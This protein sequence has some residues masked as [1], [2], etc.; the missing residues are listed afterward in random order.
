M[1]FNLKLLF[2]R[3]FHNIVTLI[4]VGTV[5]GS[6]IVLSIWIWIDYGSRYALLFIAIVLLAFILILILLFFWWNFQEYRE[7]HWEKQVKKHSQEKDQRNHIKK[8]KEGHRKKLLDAIKEIKN[9][10]IKSIYK[11]PWFLLIGEPGSGKTRT[12][13]ESRLKF[14]VGRQKIKGTKGTLN[15]DWWFTNEAI[16]IDTAGRF[17]MP[18]VSDTSQ[19]EWVAFLKLL[20]K[21]RPKCPI[22]GVIVTIPANSLLG[23][24][25]DDQGKIDTEI[26]WEKK[27]IKIRD[28]LV[29]LTEILRVEYP[30]YIMV[31][32]LDKVYGFAEFFA[33]FSPEECKQ[34][35]G[36]DMPED[37]KE[38]DELQYSNLFETQVD[39]LHNIALKIVKKIPAGNTTNQIL[40]F[41]NEFNQL[42]SPLSIYLKTIF[43]K[44]IFQLSLLWR[45]CYFTSSIQ[46]GDTK[47]KAIAAGIGENLNKGI[48]DKIKKSYTSESRA[49][50]VHYF[51]K[52]AFREPTLVKP[53]KR[54]TKK[55]KNRRFYTFIFACFLFV[56]SGLLLISGYFSLNK[57]VKPINKNLQSTVNIFKQSEYIYPTTYASTVKDL[58]QSF[59]NGR[60]ELND[61]IT[62]HL[63]LKG[64]Q[65]SIVKNLSHI[66][67]A[68][69]FKGIY[70]PMLLAVRD[71]INSSDIKDTEDKKNIINLLKVYFP[72]LDLSSKISLENI[73]HILKNSQYEWFDITKTELESFW[74]TYSIKFLPPAKDKLPDEELDKIL[75][76]ITLLNYYWQYSPTKK[77]QK[78][79]KIVDQISDS[80]LRILEM[81]I[82]SSNVIINDFPIRIKEFQ[83]IAKKALKESKNINLI[84]PYKIT[85]ICDREYEELINSLPDVSNSN[86]ETIRSN[87]NN[88]RK[89]CND[90]KQY[91]H[92]DW[93]KFLEKNNHLIS[94]EGNLSKSLLTVLETLQLILNVDP[95][96]SNDQLKQLEN[97]DIDYEQ[98][99]IKWCK[100]W[101][102]ELEKINK[103]LAKSLESIK[104]KGW[105]KKTLI[106]KIN[107]YF[108][109]MLWA[110][111]RDAVLHAK[112]KIFEPIT[113]ETSYSNNVPLLAQGNILINKYQILLKLKKWLQNE[114]QGHIEIELKNIFDQIDEIINES[115]YNY[116]RYWNNI[117]SSYNPVEH[118]LKTD[119]WND[120]YNICINKNG[121]IID[122]TAR[123]LNIF[124]ENVSLS[125]LNKF[126]V[127]LKGIYN[128]ENQYEK[129]LMRTAYTYENENLMSSLQS[130]QSD[131]LTNLKFLSNDP[132]VAWKKLN[133]VNFQSLSL[134]TLKI[135]YDSQAN[136]ELY[137]S[138]LKEVEDY[139]VKLLD[140][141]INSLIKN[142]WDTFYSIWKLNLPQRYP[143]LYSP[144]YITADNNKNS[145]NITIN[146]LSQIELD[147]LFYGKNGISTLTFQKQS[148]SNNKQLLIDNILKWRSFLYD[149]NAS[150]RNHKITIEVDKTLA[151]YFS[152][153]YLTGF[154]NDIFL[155]LGGRVSHKVGETYWN[156]DLKQDFKIILKNDVTDLTREVRIDG[157]SLCFFAFVDQN[158]KHSRNKKEFLID[159]DFPP[160]LSNKLKMEINVRF[161]DNIPEI[162]RWQ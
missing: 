121:L 47:A 15:C 84:P 74:E 145:K 103:N 129:K 139:G 43:D 60:N 7:K 96:L 34:I 138:K 124:L 49:Y 141:N 40:A 130:A 12:L 42:Q 113:I 45:G 154:K 144:N 65:N 18:P 16:I 93:N 86:I 81:S 131:F 156:I 89:I 157:G 117:L 11:L 62:V 112:D 114:N 51:Y 128:K 92:K 56:I 106:L 54:A 153:F 78:Q 70:K 24:A 21:Y 20:R 140:K 44:N 19:Q 69:F 48:I 28:K 104:N 94:D 13:M 52:K 75:K 83:E 97:F 98:E 146:T 80:Y 66:E 25:D 161:E 46:E 33:T 147:D 108:D 109:N 8:E 41:P 90:L 160:I 35:L 6:T 91:Y 14:P 50:F 57:S 26:D 79:W 119:S 100:K 31:S 137:S 32:K 36:W 53:A 63:F 152:D 120:F 67:D 4:I 55:E 122:K 23:L 107:Y 142:K 82:H 71:L 77:W 135:S 59:K 73:F 99:M 76:G 123:P 58:I 85:D 87:L 133:K 105:D 61:D 22:N 132:S 126:K 95:L 110:A 1:G 136:K 148:L 10:E 127:M 88:G 101:K 159:I 72:H 9:T 111:E 29:E 27:A 37:T 38:F 5:I 102:D 39:R 162:I 149:Q 2:D 125:N 3:I 17:S 151:I 143:F 115:Y 155:R 30:I 118:I 116:L 134:Y 150:S 68:L 158:T 64:E